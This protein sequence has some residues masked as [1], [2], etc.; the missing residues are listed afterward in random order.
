MPHFNWSHNLRMKCGD[1]Q[2]LW[3]NS[4]WPGWYYELAE[5]ALPMVELSRSQGLLL[6]RVAA[7]NPAQREQLALASR[8][9]E[10]L[11][12]SE[13]AGER[14]DARVVH[15]IIEGRGDVR[16]P[17]VRSTDPLAEGAARLRLEAVENG[18]QTLTPECLLS[19]HA[20]LFPS[21]FSGLARI[22]AGQW[23]DDAAEPMQMVLGPAGF[24]RRNIQAPPAA[25]LPAELVR[26]ADWLNESCPTPPVLKASLAHLWFL[27]LR[28]F[29]DGNGRIARAIADW[30]LARAGESVRCHYSVSGEIQR[31]GQ[32][33]DEI[34]ERACRQGLDATEWLAWCL[35]IEQ[36]AVDTALQSLQVQLSKAAFWR[37]L[38]ATPLSKRQLAVVQRLLDG[39]EGKLTTSLW[40]SMADCS[41]DTALRD[42]NAL[43]AHGVLRKTA[44]GGR[45]TSYELITALEP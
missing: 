32:R 42:I 33:Y 26:F 7:L 29:D 11:K 3:E 17:R 14:L 5:L 39:F 16:S 2:R 34:F 19:W 38:A 4:D 43:V 6:G 12:S 13:L 18:S 37:R 27:V 40:A 1:Y 31:Q 15:A 8:A 23:R 30:L 20:N 10:V 45:S 41:P 9:E 25:R 21:G 24:R 35:E 28:P 44:A 36:R 22:R